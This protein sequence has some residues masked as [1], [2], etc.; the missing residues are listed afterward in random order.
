ML[1]IFSRSKQVEKY[2]ISQESYD[3]LSSDIFDN[4]GTIID[5]VCETNKLKVSSGSANQIQIKNPSESTD[6][7][8]L[9]NLSTLIIDNDLIDS[10]T[11]KIT[12][13]FGIEIYNHIIT[14]I[15][16][17]KLQSIN[18]SLES[19]DSI[20][21]IQIDINDYIENLKDK[22]YINVL[23]KIHEIILESDLPTSV[24]S[25]FQNAEQFNFILIN[26]VKFLFDSSLS[27]TKEM[28][29]S[30]K[31]TIDYLYEYDGSISKLTELLKTVLTEKDIIN[32]CLEAFNIEKSS[33]VVVSLPESQNLLTE[34]DKEKPEVVLDIESQEVK[35]G[36]TSTIKQ[37]LK[38]KQTYIIT[39]SIV[40][41]I[42]SL[43]SAFYYYATY[44]GFEI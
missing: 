39:G 35:E 15:D 32:K 9:K 17:E 44:I 5:S 11:D 10:L 37:I 4:I 29:N 30:K 38:S 3:S 6:T 1:K 28:F 7:K 36:N 42:A 13:F 25:I 41:T 12:K 8:N 27:F 14:F 19:L 26:T 21:N 2:N 18:E 43:C 23:K 20:K 16:A 22:N 34:E 33:D 40:T 31:Y 24:K